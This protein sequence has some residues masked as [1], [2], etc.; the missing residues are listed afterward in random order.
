MLEDWNDVGRMG[1]DLV[2]LIRGSIPLF[3]VLVFHNSGPQ[4][5]IG[6]LKPET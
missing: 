2:G 1:A 6:H 5:S 4:L 3:H